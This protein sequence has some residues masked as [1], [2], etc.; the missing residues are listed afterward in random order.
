M[1]L[2]ITKKSGKQGHEVHIKSLI[3]SLAGTTKIKAE[4]SFV[5]AGTNALVVKARP[6]KREQCRCGVCH[7]RATGYD[8]RRETLR[9]RCLEVGADGARWIASCIDKYCPMW[10]AV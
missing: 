8:S 4:G 9:W 2:N 10:S 6:T 1:I 7:K 5:E 3:H